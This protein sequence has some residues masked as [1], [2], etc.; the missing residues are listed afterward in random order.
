MGYKYFIVL[1]IEFT[2]IKEDIMDSVVRLS[3]ILIQ[4]L[5]MSGRDIWIFP[6]AERVTGQ[7][8]WGCMDR[9]AREKLR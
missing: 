7:V 2:Y 9:T 4:D 5:R 8:F 3:G 6:T 1:F